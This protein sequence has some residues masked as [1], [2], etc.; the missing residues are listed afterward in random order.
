MEYNSQ[1]EDIT[2]AEYG[3]NVQNLL[4]HA[5]TIE[6]D[7]YRQVYVE[8]I[9][10]LMHQMNPQNKNIQE[11]R[12]KL[13]RH[14]FRI[15]DYKLKVIPTMGPIPTKEDDFVKPEMIAYPANKSK[16]RH[17]GANVQRMIKKAIAMDDEEK[18]IEYITIIASYMKLAYRTWNPQHYVNDEIIKDD[19]KD[20]SKGQIELEPGA[21]IDYLSKNIKIHPAQNRKSSNSRNKKNHSN[22][23][24]RNQSRRRN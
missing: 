19:L 12:E 18:K 16:F 24:G 23:R 2:I 14:A 20:L 17:Y 11:H 7:N 6:D 1:S 3:R 9:I 22:N 21:E 8:R 10:D 13:W 15:T 4:R 5:L